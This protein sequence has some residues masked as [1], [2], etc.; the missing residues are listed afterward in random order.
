MDQNKK[1]EWDEPILSRNSTKGND[2][3]IRTA[4]GAP[5]DN[6]QDTTTAGARG[7]VVLQDVWFME[8]MAHFDREV[9]PERRMHAKGSGAFGT[10]TVTHDITA[11]TK[12]KIFSQIG[13]KTEMFARFSTVA[14]ERGAADAERDIRG[15]ALKF[16]TE[17][18]NWDMVGNN[19]PVFFFR[20]PLKFIDLNHAVKR[21]P[22]TNMR[23]ANTNWDFWSSLPEALQQ[24]TIVMSDRGI[25]ASYR[26]MHGFSSHAY[27]FINAKN[28]RFWV[29]FHFRSQQG[30]Q[31]L[32]D[33]ESEKVVAKDRESHQRDLYEAI[34]KGN[35]PKWKLYVQIMTEAKTKAMKNNPFDLTKQWLKKDY[36]LIPV[37]EFELNRNPENY[38]ADVEQAAFAPSNVVPGIS[39]SPDRML[40][41]RLFSYGDSHRYRLGVNHHQIPVNAPRGVTQPHSFHRDGAMR[42]DG[43]LGSENH[44]EPNSYGNWVEAKEHAL[45]KEKGGDVYRYDYRE[46]DHDYYTQTR[47]LFRGMTKDQQRVL[48]ENTARNMADSTLQI[49]HRHILNCYRAD[50]KYG[51]GVA[52]SLNIPFESVDLNLPQRNSAELNRQ[53]N[54]AHPELNI[55]GEDRSKAMWKEIKTEA[56]P[57]AFIE[58]Q[59]DPYLL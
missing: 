8:K 14:G 55:P 43:N 33:Q 39:F 57:S 25:P 10:F 9:I 36:P 26:H 37:G 22:R 29:K 52:K 6:N 40:Q 24:V 42:V 48:F 45:P 46:D 21:D 27:S 32:T 19:T 15:F 2:P 23:S 47:L 18:G 13:K 31:N 4:A 12:A 58:P 50:P 1:K 56:D 49:K 30:I 44:Y 17:E 5:V 16:Y 11:Y 35:Y 28:E 54:Q 38:F 34:E 7:P 3:I 59:D 41:G 53:V 51:K 20:D